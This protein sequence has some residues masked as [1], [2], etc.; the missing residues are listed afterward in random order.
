MKFIKATCPGCGASLEL[1]DHLQSTTCPN[2]GSKVLIEWETKQNPAAY[3]ELAKRFIQAK[4]YKEADAQLTRVLEMNPDNREAWFWKWVALKLSKWHELLDGL[5]GNIGN[6]NAYIQ[7]TVNPVDYLQQS[8]YSSVD[9]SER[10]LQVLPTTHLYR[11]FFQYFVEAALTSPEIASKLQDIFTGDQIMGW[12]AQLRGQ[13]ELVVMVHDLA[14]HAKRNPISPQKIRQE[15]LEFLGLSISSVA[16]SQ[17]I[18]GPDY[19]IEKLRREA[20]EWEPTLRHVLNILGADQPDDWVEALV[21]ETDWR[22]N[23][24]TKK[25]KQKPSYWRKWLDELERKQK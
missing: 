8:R 25:V 10:L 11:D 12:G 5:M 18:Q 15:N 1:A 20:P 22:G 19:N 21:L 6:Q 17:S 4:N 14:L 23:Q 16:M 2:C 9:I 13:N 24:K 3:L 7:S